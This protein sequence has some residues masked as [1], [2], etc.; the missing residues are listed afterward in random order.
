MPAIHILKTFKKVAFVAVLS[1]GLILSAPASAKKK[2]SLEIF[3]YGGSNTFFSGTS[4]A[5]MAPVIQRAE[6][7]TLE[8]I[9]KQNFVTQ[10]DTALIHLIQGNQEKFIASISTNMLR[11]FGPD[12]LQKNVVSALIPYFQQFKEFDTKM[13]IVPTRDSWDN[14]GYSLYQ[15]FKTKDGAKKSFLIQMIVEGDAIVVAN[16]TP[17]VKSPYK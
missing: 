1:T 4:S 5:T 14:E 13:T 3:P 11:H 10:A 16:L 17:D 8:T 12:K 2:P 9:D 6:S 15:S 7:K